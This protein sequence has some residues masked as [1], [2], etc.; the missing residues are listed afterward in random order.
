MSA[1]LSS[2]SCAIWRWMTRCAACRRLLR[3]VRMASGATVPCVLGQAVVGILQQRP[4]FEM[5]VEIERQQLR[6]HRISHRILVPIRSTGAGNRGDELPEH[7]GAQ[8]ALGLFAL[9]DELQVGAVLLEV[10]REPR[11]HDRAQRHGQLH[12]HVE[13]ELDVALGVRFRGAVCRPWFSPVIRGRYWQLMLMVAAPFSAA[14][15][16]TLPFGQLTV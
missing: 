13:P 8:C 9:V 15:F 11:R 5:L 16:A 14:T 6:Q 7:G 12:Q 4:E 10:I 2:H 1:T 3:A